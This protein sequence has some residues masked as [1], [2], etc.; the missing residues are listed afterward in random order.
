MYAH[1]PKGPHAAGTEPLA[2]KGG[3]NRREV[4]RISGED[5]TTYLLLQGMSIGPISSRS[6]EIITAEA[7]SIQQ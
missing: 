5:R 1:T 2:W 6:L 4:A 3:W 7:I